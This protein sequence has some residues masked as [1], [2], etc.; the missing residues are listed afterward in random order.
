MFVS[1]SSNSV[2]SKPVVQLTPPVLRRGSLV[3]M[4]S[5]FWSGFDF[6]VPLVSAL[7][8]W[9]RD[10]TYSLLE[11][12][13][14]RVPFQSLIHCNSE[15][16]LNKHC[17][18]LLLWGWGSSLN[19]PQFCCLCGFLHPSIAFSKRNITKVQYLNIFSY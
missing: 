16:P 4:W 2:P 13:R 8:W 5:F 12:G 7:K 9:S 18:I 1:H 6:L 10:N 15:I 17:K 14:A 3:N 11:R 19:R